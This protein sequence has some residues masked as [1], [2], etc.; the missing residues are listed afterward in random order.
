MIKLV[1][2]GILSGTSFSVILKPQ[3]YWQFAAKSNVDSLSQINVFADKN[4]SNRKLYIFSE[5]QSR[6]RFYKI[7]FNC[8]TVFPRSVLY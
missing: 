2:N 1:V 6:E 7:T 4:V 3:G 5:W 8:R